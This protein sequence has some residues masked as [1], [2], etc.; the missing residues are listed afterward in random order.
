MCFR[1]NDNSYKS[2]V[3]SF[4]SENESDADIKTFAAV[5]I[6]FRIRNNM[7]HGEKCFS[8]LNQQRKFFDACSGFLDELVLREDILEIKDDST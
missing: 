3:V 7:F 5:C 4:L 6:C 2:H 8:L 1:K